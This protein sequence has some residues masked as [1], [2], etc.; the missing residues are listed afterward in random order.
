[1]DRDELFT[2]W[3]LWSKPLSDE[4]KGFFPPRYLFKA[5]GF[6]EDTSSI[7]LCGPRF[8]GTRGQVVI[9][10]AP[11]SKLHKRSS[12]S[13]DQSGSAPE[14]ASI[15]LVES[16]V[17]LYHELL[18]AGKFVAGR[19]EGD[20]NWSFLNQDQDHFKPGS[21]QEVRIRWSEIF[22]FLLNT[23]GG[24]PSNEILTISEG[25][26]DVVSKLANNPRK[27]LTRRRRK[28]FLG[29]AQQLDSSCMSW[30]IRQPGR[31]AI[32]KAGSSQQIMAV[33]REESIDT[34]ENRVLKSLISLSTAAAE[35]YLSKNLAYSTSAR[36]E[37][38]L[39]YFH[40]VRRLSSSNLLEEVRSAGRVSQPNYALQQD[41]HYSRIWIAYKQLLDR[42]KLFEHLYEWRW[43][44]WRDYVRLYIAGIQLG[45]VQP[46]LVPMYEQGL[47]ICYHPRKGAIFR[48]IDWPGP[49]HDAAKDKVYQTIIPENASG[50][51]YMGLDL[52]QLL[53]ESGCDLAVIV[54]EVE[55]SAFSLH[56]I[57][58]LCTQD[59]SLNTEL[60]HKEA[61]SLALT[62]KHQAS[63]YV[64]ITDIS[65]LIVLH[66]SENN[67]GVV[68]ISDNCKI[69]HLSEQ[70][71]QWA[72][73]DVNLFH[74]D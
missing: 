39:K 57:W 32:E 40:T 24:P 17:E 30:L 6:S 53:G 74:Q 36:Y 44:A 58:A 19:G 29:Q 43:N 50:L 64:Q 22:E 13:P 20:S 15:L 31:T 62:A 4:L 55:K 28:V 70:Y 7:K 35:Q 47:W 71:S 11:A 69:M 51:F 66:A 1:M 49:I 25:L 2:P 26:R 54:S 41:E 48:T 9:G 65:I 10:E 60:V 46:D 5:E 16:F 23:H 3:E 59:T 67:E 12:C 27:V 18:R 73:I 42:E 61:Q 38:V 52:G 68:S 45:L 37:S 56:L 14:L 8:L 33:V 63:N 72:N 21:L 34:L